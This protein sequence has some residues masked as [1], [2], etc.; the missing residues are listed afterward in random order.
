MT[1]NQ[2]QKRRGR[3]RRRYYHQIERGAELPEFHRP[4]NVPH[5][6]NPVT[7][8][9]HI[10]LISGFIDTALSDALNATVSPRKTQRII[11]ETPQCLLRKLGILIA[12]MSWSDQQRPAGASRQLPLV[13]IRYL[14]YFPD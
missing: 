12:E 10:R 5:V 4:L 13:P 6:Q 7:Q 9:L 14:T 3:Y 1:T 11:C 8:A 2:G